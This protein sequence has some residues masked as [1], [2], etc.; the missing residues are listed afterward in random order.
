MSLA[1]R[2]VHAIKLTIPRIEPAELH[3]RASAWFNAS[4]AVGVVHPRATAEQLARIYVNY[5]RHA[6]TP[7]DSLM[8]LTTG[9]PDLQAEA[10]RRVYWAIA[11]AYPRLAAECARQL[12]LREEER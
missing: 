4:S 2:R 1:A 7:Y 6:C 12:Q 10:R 3:Q 11:G 5:L 8:R 9:Q